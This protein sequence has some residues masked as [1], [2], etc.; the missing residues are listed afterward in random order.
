[1]KNRFIVV[2]LFISTLILGLSCS[3]YSIE[4]EWLIRITYVS[5]NNS[6]TTEQYTLLFNKKGEVYKNGVH[7]G[8]F[9][10]RANNRFKF[11]SKD[12]KVVFYAE[13]E[14]RNT[15]KGE[16]LHIPNDSMFANWTATRIKST[17]RN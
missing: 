16:A 17:S 15:I 11:F 9:S 12:R 14:D 3:Y 7:Y 10:R 13:F 2:L 8:N 4:G 6:G 5:Q 1:M